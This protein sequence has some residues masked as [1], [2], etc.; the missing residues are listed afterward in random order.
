MLLALLFLSGCGKETSTREE[1][2]VR[3]VK[4]LAI[5]A[6]DKG[7][8][9]EFPAVIRARNSV[10]LAFNVPGQVTELPVIEGEPLAEGALL[11][12]LDNTEYKARL[13]AA[14]AALELSQTDFDRFNDLSKSGAVAIAE[15]DQK[16][17][18]LQAAKSDLELA[19]KSFEDTVLR[20][21]FDGLVSR[22]L[23]QNFTNVQAKQPV[24]VFQSVRP[25][26]VVID[27]PEPM[28]IRSA[29]DKSEPPPTEVRFDSLPGIALPV[30]FREVSTEADPQTQTFQVAFSLEDTGEITVLPGMSAVLVAERAAVG[31]DPVYLLPPLAVTA[32]TE[33]GRSVWIYD[34][35]TS[36][37]AQRE[38]EVGLLRDEGI[39]I[40][41]GLTEGDQVVVAGVAQLSPG[42][43]VRPQESR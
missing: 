31:G 2:V 25:L 15:L 30:F 14:Q 22:R 23:V 9:L 43:K 19:Q 37:V 40:I 28:V 42:M 17:A 4:I 5:T 20:A 21:P 24:M 16:R 38:V 18:A 34:P 12:S 8:P 35:A 10:E 26:D 27:V 11:A 29:Y 6:S 36:E 3:P 7:A 32:D 13:Q 33:G 1:A 41:S 39:E